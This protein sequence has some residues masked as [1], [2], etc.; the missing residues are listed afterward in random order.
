MGE[1]SIEFWI[2]AGFALIALVLG[3]GVTLAMDAKT[4]GEFR[5]AVAC[6]VLSACISIYGIGKWQISAALP[7]KAR[8]FLAYGILA[9]VLLLMSQAI[10]WARSRHLAAA[11]KTPDNPIQAVPRPAVQD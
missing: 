2:G 3:V 7:T 11:V 8:V 10:R 6:F 9:F 1:L 4:K 5:F